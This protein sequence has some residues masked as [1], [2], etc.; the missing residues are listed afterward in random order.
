MGISLFFR[1]D[2]PVDQTMLP[3]P[4]ARS[5]NTIDS[6]YALSGF[7]GF[8]LRLNQTM[9]NQTPPSTLVVE[10][11]NTDAIGTWGPHKKLAALTPY[12][13]FPLCLPPVEPN[14]AADTWGPSKNNR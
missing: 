13:V 7:P 9:P 6:A 12:L 10:P 14:N 11:H 8:G 5:V 2:D 3:R 4:P 1:N